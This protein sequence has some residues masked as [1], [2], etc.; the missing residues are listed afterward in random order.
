MENQ[1]RENQE[2]G[3]QLD[4]ASQER[5][6]TSIK[7]FGSTLAANKDDSFDESFNLDDDEN[8]VDDENNSD[9]F[10]SEDEIELMNLTNNKTN[11]HTSSSK[12]PLAND[13]DSDNDF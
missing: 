7:V 9:L 2:N 3:N 1:A 8:V 5:K 13:L 11:D 12:K 6:R 4:A 10:D